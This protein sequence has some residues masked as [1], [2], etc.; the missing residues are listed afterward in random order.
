MTIIINNPRQEI[1]E[2]FSSIR[3][4]FKETLA[5]SKK[6]DPLGP[7]T[8]AAT[9]SMVLSA[10]PALPYI[11]VLLARWLNLAHTIR[12]RSVPL[13]S[14]W[15]WWG[16]LAILFSAAVY[17]LVELGDRKKDGDQ[18]S[19]AQM[20]FAL[21]Y[22][23]ADEISDFQKNSRSSHIQRALEL[24]E[25]LFKV[26]PH[27]LSYEHLGHGRTVW[28]DDTTGELR[29][30]VDPLGVLRRFGWFRLE[31]STEKT[32]R[33]FREFRGKVHDRIKDKK[34]LT[35][36]VQIL[37][38][39]ALYFYTEIPEMQNNDDKAGENSSAKVAEEALGRFASAVEQLVPYSSER[40][41]TT[42]EE[43][44]Q[45]K[46]GAKFERL[47]GLFVHPNFFVCF[48]VWLLFLGILVCGAVW[49]S[50]HFAADLKI[51]STI[52][53]LMV[54]VPIAGAATLTGLSRPRTARP[55]VKV[56]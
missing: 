20:R 40:Q 17:V 31:P 55:D 37:Q 18:L 19:G 15:F 30:Y 39:L 28:L 8:V 49:V 45:K 24:E 22:A 12:G 27:I 23:V 21:T 2:Y 6:K 34:D 13:Q 41:P 38:A 9:I 36:I 16:A 42:V 26:I 11:A 29:P 50:R 47:G 53:A 35:T 1:S 33:A 7:L 43:K 25:E 51:D 5:A 10:I 48:I 4:A 44:L 32:L 14:F 54:G 3:D 52:V 56:K 46:V